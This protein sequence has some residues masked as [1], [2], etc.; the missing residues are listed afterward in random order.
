MIKIIRDFVD[1]LKLECISVI[2][3]L[4]HSLFRCSFKFKDLT[5]SKLL[6]INLHMLFIF[7]KDIDQFDE[8]EICLFVR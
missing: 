8:I 7:T 1:C 6:P 3:L 4:A 2:P 5:S